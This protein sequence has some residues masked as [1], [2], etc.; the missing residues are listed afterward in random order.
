MLIPSSERER[1]RTG[2]TDEAGKKGERQ[3]ERFQLPLLRVLIH[4]HTYVHAA[5]INSNNDNSGGQKLGQ[6]LPE[7]VRG[8]VVES[9]SSSSDCGSPVN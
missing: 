8:P 3:K 4:L 9:P 1:E 7:P 2:Q 6:R 5:V